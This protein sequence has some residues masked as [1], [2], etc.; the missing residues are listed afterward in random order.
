MM[1]LGSFIVPVLA[2]ELE[3]L[4]I[5]LNFMVIIFINIIEFDY[6]WE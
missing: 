3:S 6:Y 2:F 4:D 1:P 5:I